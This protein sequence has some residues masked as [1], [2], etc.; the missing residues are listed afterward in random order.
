MQDGKLQLQ[1]LNDANIWLND[2]A[3]RAGEPVPTLE[4]GDR[5]RLTAGGEPAQLIRVNPDVQA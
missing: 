3:L 1:I 4:A 5:L 2:R